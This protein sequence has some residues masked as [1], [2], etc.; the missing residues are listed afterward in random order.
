MKDNFSTQSKDY[1][2]YRPGYPEALFQFILGMV[3]EKKLA[4]D[5][6]TGNGQ[7]AVALSPYFEKVH[8]IDISE[9]QL[10]QSKHAANIIY[11]IGNAE[12]TGMKSLQYDLVTVGQAA[13]WFQLPEFYKEVQRVLKPGGVLALT[14]Y[15]LPQIDVAVDKV[16]QE[17]YNDLL[18][19]F[20]DPERQL[21]DEAYETLYFPY[22]KVEHP[23]FV[24]EYQWTLSQFLGFLGTWSAV[25]H[26]KNIHHE[27]PVELFKE[28]IS[29]AWGD[30][31]EK[32]IAFPVFLLA[33]KIN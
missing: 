33:T 11:S 14:G 31:A 8:A 27:D 22:Q 18:G 12:A 32:K 17:F 5:V 24:S 28:K 23:P 3:K 26:Y 7:V 6:A 19:P 15:M 1:A 16:L 10:Q 13:H 9:K 20:W 21:V 29:D 4:L 2:I 25:Q 30:S